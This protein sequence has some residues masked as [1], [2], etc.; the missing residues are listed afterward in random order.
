MRVL[1]PAFAAAVT[2]ITTLLLAC[3]EQEPASHPYPLENSSTL[4]TV[5]PKTIP[6][7][8]THIDTHSL[9]EADVGRLLQ[10]LVCW[11]QDPML[12]PSCVPITRKTVAALES[13]AKSRDERF[14]APL[15]DMRWLNVGWERWVEE[16]LEAITGEQFNDAR[17]WHEWMISNQGPLPSDYLSWKGRLLSVID[18]AYIEL[19]NG[20]LGSNGTFRPELLIWGGAAVDEVEPLRQPVFVHRLEERY[21][22]P[23]ELVFGQILD[24]QARAYP[25]RIIAWHQLVEDQIGSESSVIVFCGPCGGAVAYDP[26]STSSPLQLSISGLI[27]DSRVL[28]LDRETNTLWDAFSGKSILGGQSEGEIELQQRTLVTTTWSDWV[29]RHPNTTVLSLDT[30]YVRD[31]S[32]G[33]ALRADQESMEPVFPVTNIDDRL[34]AKETILGIIVEGETRA[35]PVETVRAARIIQ[36]SVGGVPIVLLSEGPGTA[37]RVYRSNTLKISELTV[38]RDGLIATGNDGG[39]GSRWFVEEG[40]LISTTDGRRYRSIPAR[41]SYWFTWSDVYPHTTIWSVQSQSDD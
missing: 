7:T 17:R 29:A 13:I 34:P 23:E 15:I 39:D 33:A 36:D 1:G 41:E 19:F 31:Y 24:G 4:S 22:S 12:A 30:G 9:T 16:A 18:P 32:I 21:L 5:L 10:E 25:R 20:D 40:A 11:Y 3:V 14:I 37:V 28:L 38:Q 35:F 26:R 6:P 8:V 27:Y 2:V